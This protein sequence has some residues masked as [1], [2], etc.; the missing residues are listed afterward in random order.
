MPLTQLSQPRSNEDWGSPPGPGLPYLY[1]IK[2]DYTSCPSINCITHNANKRN[3]C[4]P[5]VPAPFG[6][7][8]AHLV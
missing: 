3:M 7:R 4:E 1:L 2:E 5:T 8:W 6:E